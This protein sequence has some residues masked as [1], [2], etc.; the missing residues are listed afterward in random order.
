MTDAEAQI[1]KQEKTIMQQN[2]KIAQ[3]ERRVSDLLRI[4]ATLENTVEALR[5][6]LGD[7]VIKQAERAFR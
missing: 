7:D 1:A 2:V 5:R 6:K 3:L 4:K